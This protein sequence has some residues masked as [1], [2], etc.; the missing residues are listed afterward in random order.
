MNT[1]LQSHSTE[2]LPEVTAF[3]QAQRA[4]ELALQVRDAHPDDGGA[5]KAW[6]A[7]A[8]ARALMYGAYSADDFLYSARAAA[9]VAMRHGLHLIFEVAWQYH[10]PDPGR[11]S[12]DTCC[13]DLP[14]VGAWHAAADSSHAANQAVY[15]PGFWDDFKRLHGGDS[16]VLETAI[17]FLEADPWFFRSGYIKE[18]LIRFVIRCELSDEQAAR[19]RDVVMHAIEE[20]DRREFRRYCRLAR[21]VTTLEFRAELEYLAR[22]RYTLPISETLRRDKP[23]VRHDARLRQRAQWALAYIDGRPLPDRRTEYRR[24]RAMMRV[25]RRRQA[26][27]QQASD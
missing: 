1:D 17:Q 2:S 12:W 21:R 20:R 25:R 23:L 27:R 7:L 22:R 13:D 16:A 26:K 3:E 18:Y 5:W 9:E 11:A 24:S 19:L 6:E 15:P 14:A 10:H 4:V 8:T